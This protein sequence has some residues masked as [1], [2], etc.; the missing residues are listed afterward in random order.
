MQ[1]Y[2]GVEGDTVRRFVEFITP[3]S[4]FPSFRSS[5]FPSVFLL[6]RR[7]VKVLKLVTDNTI[8]TAILNRA[9]DKLN[10]EKQLTDTGGLLL[11]LVVVVV[12]VG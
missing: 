10:L 11:L 1:E 8:E 3:S 5:A 4:D 7:D 12:T 9:M 2:S 6:C